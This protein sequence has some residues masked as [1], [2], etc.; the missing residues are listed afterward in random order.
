MTTKH[1]LSTDFKFICLA[2]FIVLHIIPYNNDL[3]RIITSTHVY[4]IIYSY[5]LFV[6]RLSIHNI[7]W[8]QICIV[9]IVTRLPQQ[10][11]YNITIYIIL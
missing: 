7:H 3:S 9:H 1:G 10:Y 5:I 8:P 2:K 6:Y 4:V 11:V